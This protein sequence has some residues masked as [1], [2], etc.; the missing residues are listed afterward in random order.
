MN[1][2]LID[3]LIGNDYTICLAD[4][5]FTQGIKV[6]LIVPSN[7]VFKINHH[8]ESKRWMPSKDRSD[9]HLSKIINYLCFIVKTTLFIFKYK[10]G[11]IVHFQFFR[12]KIDIFFLLF[13]RLCN[14]K[15]VYTAHNV[16]PHE[17]KKIDQIL[18]RILYK[19]VCKIITH[20]AIT[21]KSLISRFNISQDKVSII[22]HGNFDI[23]L[24]QKLIS[25][26]EARKALNI[27]VKANVLLFFGYIREYK[28]LDL[29]LDAFNLLL[30][31]NEDI[32]LV[33][34]G[35]P[36]TK[37]LSERYTYRLN[38]FPKHSIIANLNFIPSEDV[39]KY[40]LAADYVILPYKK[41]DHSGIV[42]LAYTFGK[43]IIATQVGDFEETIEE[44]RTG[45]L[46]NSQNAEELANTIIHAFKNKCDISRMHEYILTLNKT[47]Y[48]WEE[49][50]KQ[51]LAVYKSLL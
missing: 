46:V 37:Q 18:F 3:A 49:I 2:I 40:F 47:K 13:L 16:L 1:S 36:A 41:I 50:A 6:T 51:T 19:G 25:M 17:Q 26:E 12:F 43:P 27:N 7:R 24:P 11:I 21:K 32:T 28:G 4:A 33:I 5:L 10:K 45:F 22:P 31:K 15:I 23:Y 20:S 30:K 8:F 39:A 29:L 42:H 38:N 34:A 48:S 9:S 35:F 44:G 14:I